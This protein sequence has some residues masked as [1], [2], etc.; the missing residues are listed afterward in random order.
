MK[1]IR[2]ISSV[3][4][5]MTS[6]NGLEART[7]NEENSKLK[8]IY[9]NLY[10]D[11]IKTILNYYVNVEGEYQNGRVL[12]MDINTITITADHGVM[13]GVEWIAPKEIDFE[14]VCFHAVANE[15]PSIK[16]SIIVWLKRG[17]DPRDEFHSEDMELPVEPK[18]VR[19]RGR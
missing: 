3:A 9:F 5:L 13:S 18:D 11:S 16:A 15:D 17:K 8:R 6:W 2:V 4:L 12:P 7:A 19:K 1:W 14:K 10:T